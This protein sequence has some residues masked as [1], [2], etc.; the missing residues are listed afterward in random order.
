MQKIIIL[1]FILT[2]FVQLGFAQSVE[3]GNKH[4]V[5][6]SK[7][8]TSPTLCPLEINSNPADATVFIDGNLVGTTPLKSE[9]IAGRH[10]LV[11]KKSGYVDL[12][13]NIGF[14]EDKT[15]NYTFTLRPV[16]GNAETPNSSNEDSDE[17]IYDVVEEDPS[18]PGGVAA[19]MGWMQLNFN[20]PKEALD[21]G[22]QGR[23]IMSFIVNIDGS[24]SN[25]SI[26]QLDE[27]IE[28]EAIRMILSMPNWIPGKIKG[29]DVRSK[30][31]IPLS[32]H[33]Q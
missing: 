3:G 4:E 10:S 27:S 16:G 19:L 2:M 32:F 12:S 20:Y 18:F 9:Y 23:I 22:I 5:E 29:K 8:A 24:I 25:P 14:V 31:T 6:S 28:K 11:I 13:A 33:R 15:I 7:D 21:K 1:L 26:R 30:Y 17:T